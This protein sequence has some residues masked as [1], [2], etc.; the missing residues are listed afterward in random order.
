MGFPETLE[1][2]KD[3]EKRRCHEI[4][5][6]FFKNPKFHRKLS[7]KIKI[8]NRLNLERCKK[9]RSCTISNISKNNIISFETSASKQPKKELRELGLPTDPGV[10]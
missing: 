9:F 10:K 3:L 1:I 7:E 5:A 4:F 2:C 8:L 6:R